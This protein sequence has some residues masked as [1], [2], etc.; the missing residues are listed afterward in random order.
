M[1]RKIAYCGL[2]L[3]ISQNTEARNNAWKSYIEYK[4]N[5][6]LDYFSAVCVEVF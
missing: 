1:L 2:L 4:F 5:L 6:A 3:N